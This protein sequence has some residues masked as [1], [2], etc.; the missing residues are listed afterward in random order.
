MASAPVS[1]PAIRAD[2]S[3]TTQAC[4]APLAS[5][6]RS[7]RLTVRCTPAR[8]SSSLAAPANGPA[9]TTLSFISV[10][11]GDRD[12]PGHA[13][14]GIAG[15]EP[16]LAGRAVVPGAVQGN[17]A[18]DG[19]DGP[20]PVGDELGIMAVPAPHPRA[21]ESPVGGQQPPEHPAAQFQQARADHRLGGLH[22]GIPAAQ[23][24]RGFRRQAAYLGGSLLRERPEEPPFSPPIPGGVLAGSAGQR[25]RRSRVADR[26]VHLRHLTGQVPEPLIL[27]HLPPDLLQFRPRP[28]VPCPGPSFRP[29]RQVV[30]R[31]MARMT[32]RRAGA[33]RLPALAAHLV[34]ATPAGNPRPG[35]AP[36]VQL[37]P[38]PLQLRQLIG[39]LRH[40]GLQSE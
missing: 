25:R 5:A 17:Q 28:Q 33:V 9:A 39:F 20:V 26:L 18:E 29:P 24:P 21:A 15:S 31:A 38:P 23:R 30:L 8:C 14:L 34:P 22:P 37:L 36:Q 3:R 16:V 10:S 19:V 1:R 35:S 11:P 32:R 12:I 2:R 13:E 6:A 40:H 4:A 27:S 7:T